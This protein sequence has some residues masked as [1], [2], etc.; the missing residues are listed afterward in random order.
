MLWEYGIRSA[1]AF[2]MGAFMWERYRPQRAF[3][4]SA[5]RD[6]WHRGRKQLIPSVRVLYSHA[7][8]ANSND[9]IATLFF[10]QGLRG[11][12]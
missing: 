3:W 12:S 11:K 8:K 4:A 7:E 10:V 5:V 9:R 6:I 1:G 2:Y